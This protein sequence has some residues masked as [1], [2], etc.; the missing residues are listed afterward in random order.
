[1][2]R[3]QLAVFFLLFFS[4]CA[5]A[6]TT[7][8][9]LRVDVSPRAAALG[10]SFTAA[11]DDPNTIF[12]N[13]AAIPLQQGTP[14]GFSF[15]K[16]LLDI[17]L[18]GLSASRD[19]EGIG[20]VAGGVQ[21]INY[22]TFTEAD[23]A[24]NK[25]GDYGAGELAITAGYGNLLDSNFYYG[26]NARVIYSKISSYSSSAAS[27]D[28]GLL[29]VIP[30][31]NIN[32]GFSIRDIGGQLSTYAGVT[33]NLPVD[34]SIGV[35]K[36]LQYLPFRYFIDFHRLNAERGSFLGRFNG[37]SAGGEFTLGKALKLRVG[38]NN[39][40][41]KDLKIGS[42][43]GLAGFNLGLGF[44]VETYLVDYSYSSLGQIGALHRF[45]VNTSF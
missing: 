13:P 20:R 8:D 44:T 43:A 19:F 25:Y 15:V 16:H 4:V 23:D 17:N 2:F 38:Y 32:F 41:R 1:M 3:R 40:K 34:I 18:A 45:G 42:F 14:V 6:Q 5:S 22:G 11:T 7:Y 21:Y 26:A 12:Y 33:E 27:F 31:Q 37:F 29:Y 28:V 39:E 30:S 10:G 9:F 24:G 36:K 35:S